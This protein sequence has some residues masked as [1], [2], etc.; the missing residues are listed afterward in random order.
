[1]SSYNYILEYRPISE[2]IGEVKMRMRKYNALGYFDENIIY[3]EIVYC[4]Q[5]LG[6]KIFKRYERILDIENGRAEKPF[7]FYS[8]NF[9]ALCGEFV[10]IDIP[11]QGFHIED[12]PID[13]N[14][15]CV[16][17]NAIP[18]YLKQYIDISEPNRCKEEKICE[19]KE[20]FD[21]P[22][23]QT[24]DCED[25]PCTGDCGNTI[26]ITDSKKP[27]R[28]VFTVCD[29]KT[30]E[31]WQIVKSSIYRYKSFIPVHIETNHADNILTC[32]ECNVRINKIN[33]M[34]VLD[35]A[36]YLNVRTGKLY[37]N[38]MSLPV[39]EDGSELLVPSHPVLWRYFV[40][41][42]M[43][44]IFEMALIN[45][46]DKNAANLLQLIYQQLSSARYQ[47]KSLV[48]T[49]SWREIRDAWRVNRK[50]MK[51]IYYGPYL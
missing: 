14:T 30:Y 27:A 19:E 40:Y 3:S 39:S 29:N 11:P 7:G 5:D 47:A 25:K 43:Y 8:L 13:P 1:M 2:L 45:N 33:T 36:F 16:T 38:Y 18:S 44:S 24:C 48:N 10:K 35:D 22:N 17:L 34:K 23:E 51:Y 6:I 15:G 20:I 26:C 21:C 31:V 9:A 4:L 50:L 32:P 41:H 46:S 49:P 12:I 37:I 28:T 42:L